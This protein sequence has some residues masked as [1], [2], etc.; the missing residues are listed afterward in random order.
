MLEPPNLV[1]FYLFLYSV[2]L[3]ISCVQLKMLK[4]LN[5]EGN[6]QFLFGLVSFSYLLISKI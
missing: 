1:K 4:S 5:F 3:K 6:P 2:T